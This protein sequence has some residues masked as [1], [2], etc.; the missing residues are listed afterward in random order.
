MQETFIINHITY[1]KNIKVLFPAITFTTTRVIA[2]RYV[3]A[4]TIIISFIY[5][6][7]LGT[8][9]TIAVICFP[10]VFTYPHLH[11]NPNKIIR[12][13]TIQAGIASLL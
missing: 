4:S 2:Q 1:N 11:N 9:N 12:N 13:I 7:Q 8:Y 6:A 5:S 3:T 10:M